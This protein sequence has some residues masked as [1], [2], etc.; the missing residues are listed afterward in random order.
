M[1]DEK[2]VLLRQNTC[3]C[4]ELEF[5]SVELRFCLDSLHVMVVDRC[6]LLLLFGFWDAGLECWLFGGSRSAV[7]NTKLLAALCVWLIRISRTS[8]STRPLLLI[9]ALQSTL[10]LQQKWPSY[11]QGTGKMAT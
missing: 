11:R 5:A 2:L 9:T 6:F 8:F 10:K 7:P 4:V 3:T 1:A